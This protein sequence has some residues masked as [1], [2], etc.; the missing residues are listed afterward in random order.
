[1]NRYFKIVDDNHRKHKNVE[2][3]LPVRGT[4]YSAGYDFFS[5]EEIEIKPNEKYLFWTDIKANML[6]DEVLQI[7]VRSSIGIKKGLTLANITG[8]IDKDYYNNEN[9]DGNVG[10]CLRNV[11]TTSVKIEKYERI[12]QG[13]FQKYLI[14]DDDEVNTERTGGIGHT[15]KK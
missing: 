3:K 13:I 15:D 14:T 4:K 8:I 1:M 11:G 6:E 12:A 10:I 7:H 9:N 2:I 5:N